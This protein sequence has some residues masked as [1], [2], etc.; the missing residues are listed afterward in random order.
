MQHIS[1]RN[2]IFMN[3]IEILGISGS[4]QHEQLKAELRKALD[5]FDHNLKIREVSD[6]DQ[7]LEAD[8]EAIPALRLNGMVIPAKELPAVEEL[9]EFLQEMLSHYPLR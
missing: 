4:K 9:P 8:I 2:T 1:V 7:L 5:G 6:L 3:F